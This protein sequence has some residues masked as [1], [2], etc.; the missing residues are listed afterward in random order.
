M[1]TK[2]IIL[3]KELKEVLIKLDSAISKTLLTEEVDESMILKPEK[4]FNYIDLSTSVKGHLSYLTQEKMDKIDQKDDNV[5]WE[6]KMRFHARP[7]SLIKK[8][9]NNFSGCE[10]E[11]FA[12]QFLSIV[13]PPIYRME[14]VKGED[15]AK[16]YNYMHYS[17]QRGSLGNSCMKS[18]DKNY[19]DI[20]VNNPEVI[21]MLIMLDQHDKVMGRAIVWLDKNFTIMDRVYTTND[22]FVNYFINW[23]KN[24]NCFYKKFNNCYSPKNMIYD[25]NEK[26][27]NFEIPL[28]KSKFERYP[29]LDTFKW[30]DIKENIIYNYIPKDIENIITVSDH[31]GGYL[32]NTYYAFC[33]FTNNLHSP[34]DIVFLKYANKNAYA[35]RVVK[36]KVNDTMIYDE[37][38]IYDDVLNDNIFNKEYDHLNNHEK[39]EKE[40]EK[41]K[42]MPN[43][44]KIFS[45]DFKYLKYEG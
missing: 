20:Y 17:E 40:R 41:M 45:H 9:F 36:S 13:D 18:V 21:N 10:I 29:Y 35:G 44:E 1:P 4:N 23:A 30:L 11:N 6:P 34:N 25:S 15:I 19:F 12:T 28:K 33:D 5:F 3:S 22:S 32:N 38:Y 31:M 16:Y 43:D 2:K 42:T 37:H 24:N 26:I 8:M 7:G 39:I 14:T 27:C